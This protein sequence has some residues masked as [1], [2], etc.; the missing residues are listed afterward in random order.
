M[1]CIKNGFFVF[2]KGTIIKYNII[3][4][5][6]YMYK[7]GLIGAGKMG[8]SILSGIIDAKLV[9]KEDVI[10][11]VRKQE[12]LE[13]L[14]KEGFNVT[15]DAKDAYKNSKCFILAIKPQGF[16][17]TLSELQEVEKNDSIIISVAAG[18]KID[19][20]KKFLKGEVVRTMPNTPATIKSGTTAITTDNVSKETLDE[21]IA[22]FKSI[23]S[24]SLI[25]ESQMDQIIPCN[26]SM[27]AF[28]FY[29]MD[30][31]IKAG[32][33]VGLSEEVAK[34]LVVNTVLG[35]AKLALSSSKSIEQLLIDVCSPG[36]TT[37][38]GI[39]ALD[40]GNVR[41]DIKNCFI[42]CM[43]R[44]IELGKK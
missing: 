1:Q 21:A 6:L 19:Y 20:I 25:S 36:G 31:F 5:E 26:G 39:K 23:G 28:V 43:N 35:S 4:G 8:M 29:F 33:S 40:N 9:I 41:E 7:I 27:P 3:R 10:V 16:S 13:A 37:I 17:D 12:K 2:D 34:E 22:I 44:S 38:E 18:I 15:L 11:V 14:K 32:V 24:V 42:D 30:S